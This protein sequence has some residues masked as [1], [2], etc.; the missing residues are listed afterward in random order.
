MKQKKQE[1]EA[2]FMLQVFDSLRST[3]MNEAQDLLKRLRDSA[4][5]AE[6]LRSV[7]ETDTRWDRDE[8]SVSLAS[9]ATG[10]LIYAS[11]N[12]GASKHVGDGGL[13]AL[14]SDH[15]K[16]PFGSEVV[17]LANGL[18]IPC[19]QTMRQAIDS[20]FACSGKLFHVVTRE[21]SEERLDEVFGSGR[22]NDRRTLT[23]ATCELCSIAA[24]G[25][26][27]MIKALGRD[28]EESCFG[29]ARSLLDT[30]IESSPLQ[31]AKCCTLL[32]M[33]RIMTKA[34]VALA[35]IEL[36]LS[37]SQRHRAHTN[38]RPPEIPLEI[39]IDGRRSAKL[40]TDSWISATLGYV[41]GQEWL[42]VGMHLSDFEIPGETNVTD[43]VQTEMVKIAV[44]K[45]NILFVDTSFDVSSLNAFDA[46]SRDLRQWY[47][48]IPVAMRL[49]NLLAV[50]NV[51]ITT[52][53]RRTIYYVHLLALGA[54]MLLYRRLASQ[55]VT[56]STK[57]AQDKLVEYADEAI[58]A[59]EQSARI[60]AL[61]Q[62]EDGIFQ[63]C[64]ICVFQSY[65]AGTMILYGVVQ[66]YLSG[67]GDKFDTEID[68]AT[69]CI[70]IL[71]YCGTSDTVAQQFHD[72]LAPF[73]QTIKLAISG[74]PLAAFDSTSSDNR[75]TLRSVGA[76]LF[77]LVRKPFGRLDEYNHSYFATHAPGGKGK[78]Y[79]AGP[80]S[81]AGHTV[82]TRG[83]QG[84]D[85]VNNDGI[86]DSLLSGCGPH[87][88]MDAMEPNGWRYD[89][90][91][92]LVKLETLESTSSSQ[93]SP[94]QSTP[95][96]TSSRQ[97]P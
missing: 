28:F 39:W 11:E 3:P 79:E 96:A 94:R 92:A 13:K 83:W 69:Q 31:A 78:Q 93:S 27:Y 90:H 65:S 44:L 56:I 34:T 63:R 50:D 58:I 54:W 81:S 2:A 8:R 45:Q 97:Q 29:I 42:P 49:G 48:D 36:G 32:A 66:K 72:I 17:T 41:S 21:Q 53:V 4:T 19:E 60:L 70:S 76:A 82:P 52:E 25:A 64:W 62:T 59:A 20:F 91:P 18:V 75:T 24:T 14:P 9:S 40:I 68:R 16:T 84:I 10:S 71:S 43:L 15:A 35:Y 74:P 12:T 95:Y 85:G 67:R 51:E 7:Q 22:S 77:N 5:S 1:R 38:F 88:F 30:A 47:A 89:R 33:S 61:L 86:V 87:H 26:Q 23:L 57:A 46:V 80:S 73:L 6:F 55:D 37:L